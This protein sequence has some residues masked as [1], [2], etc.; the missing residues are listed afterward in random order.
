M[1]EL[2]DMEDVRL[3]NEAKKNDTDNKSSGK[4]DWTTGD[5]DDEK[6][7]PQLQRSYS[8]MSEEEKKLK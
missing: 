6:D 2:E 7:G 4:S 8:S 1:E 3:Y 5:D